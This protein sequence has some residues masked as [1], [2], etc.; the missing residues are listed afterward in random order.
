MQVT[1]IND[2]G[3]DLWKLIM[4]LEPPKTEKVFRVGTQKQSIH[5]GQSL[6]KRNTWA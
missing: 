1:I 4:N 2:M 5:M 6:E 3:L